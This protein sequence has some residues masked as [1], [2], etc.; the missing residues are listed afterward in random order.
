MIQKIKDLFTVY[1]PTNEWKIKLGCMDIYVMDIF[2]PYGIIQLYYYFR[3]LILIYTKFELNYIEWDLIQ[4]EGSNL[5]GDT[6]K[7][8]SWGELEKS[9]KKHNVLFPILLKTLPEGHHSTKDWSKHPPIENVYKYDV[10]DG[11]HRLAVLN[12]LYGSNYKVKCRII[13]YNECTKDLTKIL[14][15]RFNFYKRW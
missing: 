9:I 3:S 6:D 14:N 1:S 7:D 4:T 12:K 2:I 8:Y 5:P 11:Y 15:G 13:D 10:V